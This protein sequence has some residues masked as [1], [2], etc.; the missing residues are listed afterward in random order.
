VIVARIYQEIEQTLDDALDTPIPVQRLW[1]IWKMCGSPWLYPPPKK[2]GKVTWEQVSKFIGCVCPQF[3]DT[4]LM[5]AY[6]EDMDGLRQKIATL[7]SKVA[8]L[9]C[10][11]S[12]R[13]HTSHA[14]PHYAQ[15]HLQPDA[16]PEVVQAAYKALVRLHHPD[17]GGN[18]R[19]MQEINRA[20][21]KI[22]QESD[23]V[24]T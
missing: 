7:E 2:R 20:M 9:Q 5:P 22:R 10:E 19:T 12:Q 6:E 18:T 17:T 11:L 13:L 1:E 21:G 16:P 23:N 4:H 14:P 3:Y 8:H 24:R 15:L